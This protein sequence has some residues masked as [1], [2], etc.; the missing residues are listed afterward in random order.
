MTGFTNAEMK[1][2]MIIVFNHLEEFKI[3]WNE[4]FK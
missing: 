1:Q 2:I 3:K 4:Y